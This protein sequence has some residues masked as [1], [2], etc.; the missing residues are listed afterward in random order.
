M[1]VVPLDAAG[2]EGSRRGLTRA[3]F[4]VSLYGWHDHAGICARAKRTVEQRWQ[5]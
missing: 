5:L 2:E 1:V 4:H 3:T